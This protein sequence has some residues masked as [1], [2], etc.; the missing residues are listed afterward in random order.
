MREAGCPDFTL[1]SIGGVDW[2][3]DLTPWAL[4][5]DAA[6]PA[7]GGADA[8][9]RRLLGQIL[10]QAEQAV[11]GQAPWRAI[12]GYSLGGLFALYAL[13]RTDRF[14]RAASMSG[15]LWFPGF[16]DY[17]RAHGV[18][19]RPS[20]V[21]LSLGRR[22][23]RTRNR[24]LRTVRQNTEVIEAFY[25]SQGVNTALTLHPGGHGQDVPARIAAGLTWL[26]RA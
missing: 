1:V 24:S 3:R 2:A 6:C 13:C 10:P 26:L 5:P 17:L 12:A 9:L 21:Y 15:S 20:H 4:P 18:R 11:P 25:R 23:N 8:Y 22:E 19:H 7:G 16:A 14:A